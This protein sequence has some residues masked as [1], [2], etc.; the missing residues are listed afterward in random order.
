MIGRHRDQ[1]TAVLE[2]L[3]VDA[4][5]HFFWFGMRVDCAP[6]SIARRRTDR[7]PAFLVGAVQHH[8][9]THFYMVGGPI[10]H[11]L[12]VEQ[13]GGTTDFAARLSLANLGEG[14]WDSGWTVEDRGE[15][16]LW[17]RKNGLRLSIPDKLCLS[18][19]GRAPPIGDMV[20][21]RHPA[22]SHHRS[23]GF[24][25]AF[26]NRPLDLR[27]PGGIL[28]LYLNIDTAGAEAVVRIVTDRLNDVQRPFILKVLSNP[29]AY[30]R[31]DN[32]VLYCHRS[33]FCDV[34][35]TDLPA[36]LPGVFPYLRARIPALTAPLAEGVGVAED[37][38]RH[39]S[40]G[41]DRC[42][43][44]AKAI[45]GAFLARETTMAGRLGM[46]ALGFAAAGIDPEYP[47][48]N[49]GSD[50][51][52]GR[53]IRHTQPADR[54]AP[55]GSAPAVGNDRFLAYA[56]EIADALVE[57][58]I[59]HRGLCNWVASLGPISEARPLP[60]F[61]SLGPN[62]YD[63]TSG[64]ALFLGE[65]YRI[66]G[67]VRHR[68]TALGA[69]R[70][71]IECRGRE[72]DV[73]HGLYVGATGI[74]LAAVRLQTLLGCEELGEFGAALSENPVPKA[75]G[76]DLISGLSGV[77]IG[78]LALHAAL[79][80]RDFLDLA[81]AAGDD[82]IALGIEGDGGLSW[83]SANA[84][85]GRNLTGL[86][87]GAA[88]AAYALF[89]LHAATGSQRFGA[90]GSAAFDYEDACF[91]LA[92]GNWPD[93]RQV[94]PGRMASAR[95][96]CS[97]TWCHGAPGIAVS[98]LRAGTVH[99]LDST[100]LKSGIAL[101]TT[102]DH[103]RTWLQS[104]QGNYSLCHGL[105]GNADILHWAARAAAGHCSGL[106]EVV[107][108]TAEFGW[109]T[110]GGRKSWPSGVGD[111]GWNPSLMLGS[112][113]VGNFYLRLARSDAP[114]PTAPHMWITE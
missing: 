46:V 62:L 55:S 1:I 66:S 72:R 110:Y 103:L 11:V 85:N 60:R 45:V 114:S 36:I 97:T 54:A 98:R 69:I 30:G 61:G 82:L 90:A 47:Y 75:I 58:A 104:R 44:L 84:L 73:R 12:N 81:I 51:N 56:D 68:D 52:V 96:S 107:A 87:H 94:D 15:R 34:R 83:E 105:A 74:A 29:A 17:V 38:K 101:K 5:T 4:S 40:F 112:A 108:E 113:G 57:T 24:Y 48:R 50:F 22:G 21:V 88:G 37:P 25:T 86:S 14:F 67:D 106:D 89:E 2:A 9:Y 63:G 100:R 64:I 111:G 79:R 102:R 99:G 59:W 3:T 19:T 41:S 80:R 10:S 91:D 13:T 32:A 95:V 76:H 35:D 70:H 39:D 6:V 7:L 71:A 31:C 33:D 109:R 65:L 28:R 92:S 27:S 42:A 8:L 93:F 78:Y 77:I 23:P 43:A 53:A 16:T 18:H 49:L 26:A 20:S